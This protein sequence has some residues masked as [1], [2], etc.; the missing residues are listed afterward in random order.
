MQAATPIKVGPVAFDLEAKL[1]SC[2]ASPLRLRRQYSLVGFVHDDAARTFIVAQLVDWRGRQ[3]R[4]RSW[5]VEKQAESTRH[6]M[7]QDLTAQIIVDLRVSEITND[8]RS[9]RCFCVGLD[10]L[11]SATTIG[12]SG[13]CQCIA[14]ARDQF[15]TALSF[16]PANWMARFYLAVSLCRCG[17]NEAA[18]S[19]FTILE[20]V[21]KEA[22]R[23]LGELHRVDKRHRPFLNPV[24]KHLQQY[25]QCPFL[26]LYNRAMALSGTLRSCELDEALRTLDRMSRAFNRSDE[27]I[28]FGHCAELLAETDRIRFAMLALSAKASILATNIEYEARYAESEAHTGSLCAKLNTLVGEFEAKF[29]GLGPNLISSAVTGARHHA[30]CQRPGGHGQPP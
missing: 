28:E 30:K 16:D 21:L 22:D 8:C 5:R 15:Q 3:L 7:I 1:R 2:S 12:R 25:P 26:V 20:R 17:E 23:L 9:Y 18:V 19:H 13:S 11:A 6:E 10:S 14:S 24:V 4:G 27:N 29:M